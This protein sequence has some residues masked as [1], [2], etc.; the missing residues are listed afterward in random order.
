MKW[1]DILKTQGEVN[2][3]QGGENNENLS[4]MQGDCWKQCQQMLQ[5]LFFLGLM[6]AMAVFLLPMVGAGIYYTLFIEGGQGLL[7]CFPLLCSICI[8][9]LFILLVNI[10]MYL[11]LTCIWP[12]LFP[13]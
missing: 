2:L 5:L 4:E 7:Q 3:Q 11:F 10:L 6:I 8:F 13:D 12:A 1:S 9:M